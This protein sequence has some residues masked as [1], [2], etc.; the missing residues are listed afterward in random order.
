M[1]LKLYERAVADFEKAYR[2]KSTYSPAEH[3]L[4]RARHAMKVDRLLKRLGT[5]PTLRVL[6]IL[7]PPTDP[8]EDN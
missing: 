3:G 1:K 6:P 7:R 4:D 2:I 8:L 5:P